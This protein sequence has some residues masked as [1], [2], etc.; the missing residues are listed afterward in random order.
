MAT[1]PRSTC[2]DSITAARDSGDAYPPQSLPN[3]NIVTEVHRNP[4]DPND[5]W[6]VRWQTEQQAHGPAAILSASIQSHTRA[7]QATALTRTNS[8]D[9]VQ[10]L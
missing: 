4:L 8:G 2:N 10:N 7:A 1:H 3:F 5:F 6:S 9:L